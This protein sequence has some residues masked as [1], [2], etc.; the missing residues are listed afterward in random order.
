MKIRFHIILLGT[1]TGGNVGSICRLMGNYEFTS[2]SL[3]T[4][5][6]DDKKKAEWLA[7]TSAG[8]KN[9]N[10]KR[11]YDSLDE[12][13]KDRKISTTIGFTRRS[14][15]GREVSH[16]YREYFNQFFNQLKQEHDIIIEN[17]FDQDYNKKNKSNLP[18]IEGDCYNVGLLFGRESSGL[19]DDEIT[20]CNVLAYIPTS[21]KSPSLNLAQAANII[22]NELFIHN[23]NIGYTNVMQEEDEFIDKRAV[24]KGKMSGL[25]WDVE[26]IFE[27]STVDERQQFFQDIKQAAMKKNMLAKNDFTSFKRLFER[28]F[29]SPIVT[30]KDLKILKQILMRFLFADHS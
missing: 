9:L 4:P 28:I 15:K 30:K 16:P 27:L 24:V 6:Y 1:E 3:V 12:A 5:T 25:R 19:K 13:L 17:G 8:L 14:G 29:A 22:M 11:I 2:L 26:E 7:H 23:V 20:K 21:P 18:I 10:A